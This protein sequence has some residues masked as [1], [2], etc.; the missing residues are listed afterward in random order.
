MRPRELFLFAQL[1][2]KMTFQASSVPSPVHPLPHK[3]PPIVC[4]YR[5]TH[6]FSFVSP[7]PGPRGIAFLCT[8]SSFDRPPR[9]TPAA[10]ASRRSA[11]NS[12]R[13]MPAVGI[14][15]RLAK[16][17]ISFECRRAG[18]SF[19]R[20]R[21]ERA[22]RM[23]PLCRPPRSPNAPAGTSPK[24][25]PTRAGPPCVVSLSRCHQLR[26]HR[27]GGQPL[28][29]P[30]SERKPVDF[31]AQRVINDAGPAGYGHLPG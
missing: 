19:R 26:A 23:G 29:L 7:R 3:A 4:H 9:A 2:T 17:R 12:K 14:R 21:K 6:S 28:S 13:R 24:L 1:L 16:F 8:T 15:Q 11:T 30:G 22:G 20:E 10:H 25:K 18:L 5:I 27:G 31:H